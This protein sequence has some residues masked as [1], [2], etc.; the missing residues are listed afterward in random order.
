MQYVFVPGLTAQIM[1][2]EQ[3]DAHWFDGALM[4]V[5]DYELIPNKPRY[6]SCSTPELYV[7]KGDVAREIR[8]GRQEIEQGQWQIAVNEH[9]EFVDRRVLNSWDEQQ[10]TAKIPS[11]KF[12]AFQSYFSNYYR[13]DGTSQA[14]YVPY[15]ANETHFL[16]AMGNRMNRS[17]SAPAR[18]NTHENAHF[19]R[20]GR[21]AGALRILWLADNKKDISLRS[22]L[23]LAGR[24][25]PEHMF[26]YEMT[27]EYAKE[28]LKKIR[29]L[30]GIK[31]VAQDRNEGGLIV[32]TKELF[33]NMPDGSKRKLGQ[34]QFCIMFDQAK[35]TGWKWFPA[36]A[37]RRSVPLSGRQWMNAAG[38]LWLKVAMIEE[39]PGVFNIKSYDSHFLPWAGA[40]KFFDHVAGWQFAD[41]LA[42]VL[43]VLCSFPGGEDDQGFWLFPKQKED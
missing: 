12:Y 36:L 8:P 24:E 3:I 41:A 14:A 18:R 17:L 19:K 25:I 34:F 39:N 35:F 43:E 20:V 40:K 5:A 26:D 11:L 21:I 13:T 29:A 37:V 23:L 6:E 28:Q 32:D 16:M 10:K 33:M 4:T 2:R 38:M 22:D 7:I 42:L 31:Q 1:H 15:D 9:G 27:E 30:P